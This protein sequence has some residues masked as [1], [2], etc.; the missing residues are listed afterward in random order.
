M[1]EPIVALVSEL[2]R[3]RDAD[4]QMKPENGGAGTVGMLPGHGEDSL[5]ALTPKQ[6]IFILEYLKDF[7]A[8]RAAIGAGYSAKTAGPAASRL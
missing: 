4:R 1:E 2:Q 5:S 6:R 8:S 3:R 7:N